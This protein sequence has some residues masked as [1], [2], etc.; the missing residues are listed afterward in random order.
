[1]EDFLKTIP[2][3]PMLNAFGINDNAQFEQCRA[4]SDRSFCK[5]SIYLFGLFCYG[6]RFSGGLMGF[7]KEGNQLKTGLATDELLQLQEMILQESGTLC[8]FRS[9]D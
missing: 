8:A 4:Q 9:S 6:S 5:A 1:M 2:S 7:Q 3:P